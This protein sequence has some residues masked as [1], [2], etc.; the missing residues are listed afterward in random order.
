MPRPKPPGRHDIADVR[1]VVEILLGSVRQHFV[2][3]IDDFG[4]RMRA[5]NRSQRLIVTPGWKGAGGFDLEPGE[6]LLEDNLAMQSGW[7]EIGCDFE[8]QRLVVEHSRLHKPWMDCWNDDP[9]TVG[10][11]SRK[12][13]DAVSELKRRLRDLILIPSGVVAVGLQIRVQ[14]KQL[15]VD[16]TD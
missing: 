3:T 9:Q 7:L 11:V 16:M 4:C 6:V 1:R 14:A 2:A 8:R 12:F 10:R 13:C 5:A 15:F